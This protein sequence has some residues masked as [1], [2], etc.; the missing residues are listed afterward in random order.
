MDVGNEGYVLTQGFSAFAIGP[1]A[2]GSRNKRGR[3]PM[4]AARNR[5]SY[6]WEH[7]YELGKFYASKRIQGQ[8]EYYK[9]VDSI[10]TDLKKLAGE[11][12]LKNN[13]EN[14][15]Y[16]DAH[17]YRVFHGYKG[18]VKLLEE[19]IRGHFNE[20]WFEKFNDGFFSLSNNMKVFDIHSSMSMWQSLLVRDKKLYNYKPRDF[21]PDVKRWDG[22]RTGAQNLYYM[23]TKLG[24]E[25]LNEVI[26]EGEYFHRKA[27]LSERIHRMKF[28]REYREE[29]S[30]QK[31]IKGSVVLPL[32][33]NDKRY[34]KVK[35]SSEGTPI[36]VNPQENLFT[37]EQFEFFKSN[38]PIVAKSDEDIHEMLRRHDIYFFPLV[39]INNITSFKD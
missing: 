18:T 28:P 7:P 8:D 31:K 34:R 25:A 13:E 14:A 38:L 22:I 17:G 6:W 36:V 32:L 3:A 9:Y 20:G 5:A 35:L 15:V 30:E 19:S 26:R 21:V 33:R 24:V 16:A 10:N 29:K 37:D 1:K 39:D 27:L 4:W 12:F 11:Y 23:P 2:S